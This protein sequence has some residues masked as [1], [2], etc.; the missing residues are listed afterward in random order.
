ME[1]ITLE[2]TGERNLR[3]KGKML[4]SASSHRINGVEQNRWTE[5]EIYKTET[6]KYVVAISSITCWQ[7]E[8]NSYQVE[9]CN[10]PEEVYN[11]LTDSDGYGYCL[12]SNQAK[13]AL[14]EAAEKEP[15]LERVLVEEI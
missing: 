10:T 3:F 12:L 7:G 6:G 13:K 4:G 5:Y 2:R 14:E 1:S 15:E 9:V 11:F 8:V